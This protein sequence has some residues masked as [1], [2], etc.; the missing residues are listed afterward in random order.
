VNNLLI[1]L[2]GSHRSGINNCNVCG[3]TVIAITPPCIIGSHRLST[4]VKSSGQD[5]IMIYSV[6]F[7]VF[8]SSSIYEIGIS[9]TIALYILLLYFI[10]PPLAFILLI[11]GFCELSA[12]IVDR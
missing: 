5:I 3:R 2:D 11:N 9:A 1:N 4:D 8:E 7:F 6:N 10:I 12:R